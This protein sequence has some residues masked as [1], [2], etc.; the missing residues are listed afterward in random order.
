MKEVWRAEKEKGDTESAGKTATAPQS[1][2]A[3]GN[4][5]GLSEFRS[6]EEALPPPTPTLGAG[7]RVSGARRRLPGLG[8]SPSAPGP[9]CA[10]AARVE[11]PSQ[12]EAT[13]S[14][15]ERRRGGG[16]PVLPPA[17]QSPT[18]ARMGRVCEGAAGRAETGTEQGTE[19]GCGGTGLG[20]QHRCDL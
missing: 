17:C 13:L 12:G 3:K 18:S 5:L 20:H 4:K 11:G 6:A 15:T 16:T 2:G 7:S 14:A 8:H 19:S 9:A 1:G 10:G